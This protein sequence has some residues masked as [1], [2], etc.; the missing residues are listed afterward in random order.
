MILLSNE[1]SEIF[2]LD[3]FT[4]VSAHAQGF[5]EGIR[6][7]FSGNFY[8]LSG[9]M[10]LDGVPCESFSLFLG[11][12]ILENK[13]YDYPVLIKERQLIDLFMEW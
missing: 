10:E 2:C 11:Y 8:D 3:N 6:I 13:K 7:Y 12:L 1:D 4:Y 5:V 9:F